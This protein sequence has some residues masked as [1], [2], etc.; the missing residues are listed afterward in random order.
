[1]AWVRSC[2]Q[3]NTVE[4]GFGL[5]DLNPNQFLV[6]FRLG[7]DLVQILVVNWVEQIWILFKTLIQ[8][9]ARVGNDDW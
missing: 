9:C 2:Y 3:V 6:G 5:D 1:M 4:I 8:S 7:W